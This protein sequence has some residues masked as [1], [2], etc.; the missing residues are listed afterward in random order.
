MQSRTISIND[1]YIPYLSN[2][3]RY[4]HLWGGSG[5]GKSV[6]AAQ[7]VLIRLKTEKPHRILCIRKVANTLRSSVYQLLRDTIDDMGLNGEFTINKSEMRFIHQSGNEI[8]LAGLDDV[9][10]LKS[11]AGITSIWIE[12]ATELLESD[13]DQL[14]LR[15]RGETAN[16]K[17][18]MFTYNPISER[19]WLKARFHDKPIDEFDCLRT[20]FV[21][22][23]FIDSDY[24]K[25][26]EN[27][28][29][30]DPNLYKIYFK[31][32]W[33]VENKEGKFC[34]AFDD[35]QIK[36]TT[37]EPDRTT[38]ATFDFNVNPMT[39]TVAQVLHEIQTVRAIECVR[40]ENS[41]VYE[42]CDRLKASYP[43]ALWMIT[44]DA[45]GNSRSAM[46]KDNLTYYR[47][48]MSELGLSLAQ[49]QVPTI[50]PR[51]E[52]NKIL[53]N[54]IHKNWHI[55]IDPVKCKDLIYDLTYVEVDGKGDIIKD[56]SSSK[57]FA[58]FLDNWRYLLNTAVKPY[59]RI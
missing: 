13:F 31:G 11:I 59:F 28:A 55:E 6:F 25:V 29:M 39:C 15:L 30:S 35:S 43:E 8:L 26:L 12:E 4:L 48:I 33:G 14:D 3:K 58:D 10:K 23:H 9:E 16:Y 50:N 22:N 38:W 40:L 34:W 46:V 19:H 45:S 36:P 7:K 21:D 51:I 41:N 20:T 1:C 2:T 27:K 42:V 53:V 37:H 49:M 52:D 17:Q 44:G 57:K 47:I 54:A 24:K 32:E 18:I 5:S 56:R